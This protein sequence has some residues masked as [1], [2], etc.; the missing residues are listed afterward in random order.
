MLNENSL[1]IDTLKDTKNEQFLKMKKDTLDNCELESQTDAFKFTN[2]LLAM[3]GT[4][5]KNVVHNSH[6]YMT[7][8][9]KFVLISMANSFLT[10]C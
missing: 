6:F 5:T 2:A 10:K 9:L 3:K 1:S 7:R 4:Y 8:Y